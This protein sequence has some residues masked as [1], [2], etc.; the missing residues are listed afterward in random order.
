MSERV[1]IVNADDFGRS[2]GVNG[3]VIRSHE[4]G[5]VTSATLMVRWPG[6]A[7]AA[8]YAQRSSLSVG[9]HLDLGEWEHREGEWHARYEVLAKRTADTVAEE[10]GSQL[11]RFEQL[12]GRPPSHLDSHQ[13]VH[14]EEPVRA[15]LLR[16]GERLG[17]PVRGITPGI[18]YSGVFYG[19][20]AEGSPV[21]DAITVEALV[22]TI[23]ALPP[24]ITELGCHPATDADH[25]ST[26]DR[27]RVQ[28]VETLCDPRIRATIDHCGVALR[29]FADLPPIRRRIAP[30]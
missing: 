25:D 11:E 21:P 29:S 2:P 8:A 26:Y 7:E 14:R 4:E 15:A 30:T 9:L 17:V 22:K 18:A 5:I 12:I 6:A 16:V 3:G 13:H 27:E 20:D 24:G 23:E 10:I 19:Q 28:E 1:L